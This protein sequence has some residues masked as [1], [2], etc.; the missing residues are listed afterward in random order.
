[1]PYAGHCGDASASRNRIVGSELLPMTR[2]GLCQVDGE[3]AAW[4]IGGTVWLPGINRSAGRFARASFYIN[5]IQKSKDPVVALARVSSVIRNV[6]VP[7]GISTLG[8]PNISSAHWRPVTDHKR[9]LAWFDSE[10]E[11]TEFARQWQ[12]RGS[13]ISSPANGQLRGSAIAAPATQSRTLERQRQATASDEALTKERLTH[14]AGSTT[15]L[16]QSPK[17]GCSIQ[18]TAIPRFLHRLT[19]QSA[20]IPGAQENHGG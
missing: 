18:R 16:P 20:P 2:T 11:A 5:A 7:F 15:L 14:P 4:R 17:A 8:E 12:L 19:H 9:A 3:A 1:L 13:T 6:S 10:A